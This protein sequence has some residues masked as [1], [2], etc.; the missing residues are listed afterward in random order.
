M[1]ITPEIK[2]HLV[3]DLIPFWLGLKDERYGGFYGSVGSDRKVDM[4]VTKDVS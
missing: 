1:A 4:W 3:H 2:I